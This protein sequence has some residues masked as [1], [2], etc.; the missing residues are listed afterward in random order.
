MC[1]SSE[2][3]GNHLW[4]KRFGGTNDD[5]GL[6][7]SVDINGNVYITG[8]FKS[9]TINF[10]G[11]NLTNNGF[12]DIFLAKFDIQGNH[13]WSK[14]FGGTSDDFGYSVSADSSGN[15]YITGLFSSSTINFGGENLTNS[16]GTDIFLAKFDSN[17]NYVWSKRF[18]GTDGD[19]GN[20]VS[21]DNSGNVYITGY[22]Q[23]ST[24]NFGG[25]DL[26]NSNYPNSD[27][28]LAKFDSNGNHLWSKRYGGTGQDNGYLVSVDSSG[29]VYIT[30]YFISPTINFGGENLT[31]NGVYDIFL[32]KFDSNGNYVWSKRFGGT[33]YDF[34]LSVSVDSGGNAYI[35]GH[36]ESSTINFGGEN[37]TNSGDYDIFLAKF[38]S[39]GN[40]VWSKRFGGTSYDYGN[41]VSV[42]SSGN[43]Y[44]TG[45][46]SSSL[47]NFGGGDLTTNG[48]YDIF[49]A[50][51]DIQGNHLWSKRFGGTDVDVG[52]TVSVDSSGNVYITG[53]FV[54]S[55]INFGGDNL[56]NSGDGDI[57]LAKFKP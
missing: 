5:R 56:T 52:N 4:S 45:Y 8:Y 43:A 40:Y 21:V 27:I 23:S 38:D 16:G 48:G 39:N 41:S 34:G 18:G 37:L 32:A 54:S 22:F 42:D 46:F 50:K 36:F 1:I 29:N 44:I 11:E 30:G 26:T 51:F 20:S 28:F 35:T 55:T 24:I 13:L 33:S 47:I 15:V 12:Y 7:V 31:N 9:S 25:G 57:F 17:G 49:L 2:C 53:G 19:V 10:G 3:N 6:S 14:S